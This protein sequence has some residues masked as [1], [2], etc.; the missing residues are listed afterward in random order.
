MKRN[1]YIL[2]AIITGLVLFQFTPATGANLQTTQIV[3]LQKQV[4]ALQTT[5]IDLQNQIGSSANDINQLQGDAERAREAFT[6]LTNAL[7]TVQPAT[8]SLP[9]GFSSKVIMYLTLETKLGCN[10]A[11]IAIAQLP[12]T[13]YGTLLQCALKVIG[14]TDGLPASPLTLTAQ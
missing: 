12:I 3:A 10:G 1:V 7:G 5:V 4:K 6:T 2:G 9:A 14:T 8:N 13:G 11:G